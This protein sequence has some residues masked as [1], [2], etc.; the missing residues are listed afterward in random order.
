MEF[1]PIDV[2]DIAAVF[3]LLVA[4]WAA[5][6]ARGSRR[7]SDKSAGHAETSAKA[8]TESA[9]QSRRSAD[10]AEE[11][12]SLSKE[13]DERYDPMWEVEKALG[14]NH[15]MLA[16]AA[17]NRTGETAYG[18]TVSGEGVTPPEEPTDVLNGSAL[19]FGYRPPRGRPRGGEVVVRWR[20]PDY[21]G[22]TEQVWRGDPLQM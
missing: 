19:E 10:A 18:V 9:Q 22:S 1:N 6:H 4:G 20:R 3:A 15:S 2:G 12:T 21:R 7:A 13:Q 17:V 16:R 8:A 5:V 11:Q 14:G